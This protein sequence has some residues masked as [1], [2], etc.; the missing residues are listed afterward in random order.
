MDSHKDKE[1]AFLPVS[2]TLS[3]WDR[4]VTASASLSGNVGNLH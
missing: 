1:L 3:A 4:A 2:I